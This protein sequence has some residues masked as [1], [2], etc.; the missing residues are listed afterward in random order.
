MHGLPT[1]TE[2]ITAPAATTEPHRSTRRRAI[3]KQIARRTD[4]AG[5]LQQ[6]W[7]RALIALR[8]REEPAPAIVLGPLD[9]TSVRQ[10]MVPWALMTKVR[11]EADLDE[12]RS[13]MA[14]LPNGR[15]PVLDEQ[16]NALGIVRVADL[17]SS[18]D[19]PWI[20]ALR[21]VPN[22]FESASART[23]LRTL[24]ATRSRDA[25]VLD[26]RGG[27]VGW[28]CDAQLRNVSPAAMELGDGATVEGTFGVRLLADALDIEMPISHSD[29][30]G[31][32]MTE[33][34]GHF[35]TVGESIQLERWE[36]TVLEAT[37]MR[38]LSVGLAELPEPESL[39]LP[40]L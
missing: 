14:E 2:P 36:L 40:R 31:G 35:P 11:A 38:V 17:P 12:V 24:R 6:A 7:Q 39:E 27:L 13:A 5:R 28:L 10:L 29:S 19:Q 4:V 25:A 20:E 15:L 18:S 30:I 23:A 26:E 1:A 21:L 8:L 32:L 37:A 22:L 16:E 34:L 9:A 33:R 3:R